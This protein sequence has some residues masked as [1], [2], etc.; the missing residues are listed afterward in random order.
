M[1]VDRKA[2]SVCRRLP[3]GNNN[4]TRYNWRG[5]EL[6]DRY[7]SHY[8]MGDAFIIVTPGRNW[9]Y[10]ANPD[11]LMEVF[12]RRT[13][14]P[15]CIELTEVLNVF[16]PNMSTVDGA[17]WK[18]QRKITASCFNEQNNEIV[19]RESLALAG[20][21]LQYWT[22]KASVKTTAEDTRT[23]S[24]HVLSA[25]GFGKRF[26][27][28]GHEDRQPASRSASYKDS[29]QTILENCI[30]IMALTPKFLENPWLPRSLRRLHEACSSFQKYMTDLYQSEKQAYAEG[31]TGE[32]HLMASL[33]RAS[34]D[35]H[36]TS[37]SLT[38]RQIYGNMFIFNFAGHDT[39][40][41]TFN[42]SIYFLAANPKAQDWLA[43]EVVHVFGDPDPHDWNYH[44]LSRLKRCLSV[45]LESIRLYTP[46]PIAKWTDAAPQT[47]RI[48]EKTLCLPPKTVVIPAYSAAQTDP[49]WWGADSLVWRPSRWIK[50]DE[51]SVGSPGGE[52][53]INTKRGP[54][55]GWS[56]GARDCP[57]RK[58][59]QVEFVATISALFKVWRVDPVVLEG[60][61]IA[62]VRKRVLNLIETDSAMVLLLQM[63]HP[64][65][66]PLIWSRRE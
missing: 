13:D 47:L 44:D 45:M 5:W 21:M 66:V 6:P 26:K 32:R 14:F 63:L 42:F 24:L 61:T 55:L 35:E 41:H 57:G 53:M 9:L 15:R 18:K 23:L 2:L 59:A 30:L 28:E 58:F 8:E 17:E 37:G 40:A 46:S 27:F 29:L 19:W 60:E 10:L 50:D 62:S 1:L 64:E 4:F 38:E 33:I 16:G 31:H 12:R 39:T 3:F 36:G 25:A 56:E 7:R 65:R 11:V 51:V 22:S 52:E 49:R 48:G 43:E 34:Q 54:F 20:D